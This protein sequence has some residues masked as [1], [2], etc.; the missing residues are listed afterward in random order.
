MKKVN[1]SLTIEAAMIL[2]L[3]LMLF[4]MAMNGG[5]RLYQECRDTAISI[6]EEEEIDVIT[7]FYNWEMLEGVRK[8]EN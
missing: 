3:V 5:I 8:D 2:P 4:A 1:G 6:R 7:M